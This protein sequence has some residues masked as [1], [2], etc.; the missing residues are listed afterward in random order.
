MFQDFV[1]ATGRGIAGLISGTWNGIQAVAKGSWA[2]VGGVT[3]G[4]WGGFGTVNKGLWSG[5]TGLVKG[6]SKNANSVLGWVGKSLGKAAPYIL[7][8]VG[9]LVVGVGVFSV[10]TA[11]FG[12]A[13]A[14]VAA[15]PGTGLLSTL[16]IGALVATG[17]TVG[18]LSAKNLST[19]IRTEGPRINQGQLASER[20]RSLATTKAVEQTPVKTPIPA[21]E[22]SSTPTVKPASFT[23]SPTLTTPELST[24]S[25]GD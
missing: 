19:L 4:V 24:L 1:R 10:A 11:A 25:I 16:G 13:S 20:T 17:A 23:A 2:A 14:G 9:V 12:A 6:S 21:R 15:L 7:I 18:V 5:L 3:K 8:G 22:A